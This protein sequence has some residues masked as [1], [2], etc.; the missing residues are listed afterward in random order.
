MCTKFYLISVVQICLFQISSTLHFGHEVGSTSMDSTHYDRRI[1]Q[2][3]Q[4]QCS[5]NGENKEL[6]RSSF[7]AA[8]RSSSLSA[9]HTN[10]SHLIPF[11]RQLII[12]N[13][14]ERLVTRASSNTINVNNT[15]PLGIDQATVDVVVDNQVRYNNRRRQAFSLVK[16]LSKRNMKTLFYL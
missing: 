15:L 10:G 12:N 2:Q 14:D 9:N 8:V 13:G 1:L 5:I 3:Q 4:H 7:W 6:H 16:K 11:R